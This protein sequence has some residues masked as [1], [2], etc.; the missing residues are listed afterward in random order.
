MDYSTA[1]QIR[2]ETHIISSIIGEYCDFRLVDY[3]F[4]NR[5]VVVNFMER[6]AFCLYRRN[7]L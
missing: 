4:I 5:A 1:T 2:D 6:N 3:H 7:E